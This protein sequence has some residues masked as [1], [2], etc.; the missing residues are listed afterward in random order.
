MGRTLYVDHVEEHGTDLFRPACDRDLEGI[1]AKY[2]YGLS[3]SLREQSRWAKIKNSARA[4]LS[5]ATRRSSAM[6]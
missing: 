2:R 5:V 3:T 4:S 1:V 6:S